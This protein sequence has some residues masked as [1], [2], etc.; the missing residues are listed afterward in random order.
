MPITTFST[1]FRKFKRR[2]R[3]FQD[4]PETDSPNF[5][6]FLDNYS[7]LKNKQIDLLF[8]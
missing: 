5:N 6:N 2:V 3:I 8:I 4:I 7:S 1:S